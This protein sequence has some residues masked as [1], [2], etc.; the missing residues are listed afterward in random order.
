[1]KTPERAV[2]FT[3][4][5]PTWLGTGTGPVLT[6][7]DCCDT[8][9]GADEIEL[10]GGGET[11]AE[12]ELESEEEALTDGVDEGVDDGAEELSAKFPIVDSVVHS[13]D[14]GAGCAGG[15]TGSPW[16]NVEPP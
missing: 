9:T 6:G 16:W 10:D 12:P 14:G 5:E 4:P 8:V 11:G 15:V 1:M 7:A 2:I 3:K 13:E